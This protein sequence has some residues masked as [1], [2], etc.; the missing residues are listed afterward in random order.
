MNS[1]TTAKVWIEII[2]NR[3]NTEVKTGRLLLEVKELGWIG[4]RLC[5]ARL[6]RARLGRARLASASLG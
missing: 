4:A 2:G 3:D 5:G 1:G 6:N